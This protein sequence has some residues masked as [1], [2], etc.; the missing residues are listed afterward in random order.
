MDRVL[1]VGIRKCYKGQQVLLESGYLLYVYYTNEIMNSFYFSN[2]YTNIVIKERTV[3]AQT[4]FKVN[5]QLL[6]CL[7]Y[8]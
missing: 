2:L 3:S 5:F 8:L 7:S 4:L 1:L 6:K